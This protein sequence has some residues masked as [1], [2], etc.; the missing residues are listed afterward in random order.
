[1]RFITTVLALFSLHSAACAGMVDMQL[2]VADA[3]A[4]EAGWTRTVQTFTGSLADDDQTL[5]VL[6]TQ[7]GAKLAA[8]VACDEDCSD[9]DL[10][11]VD[12]RGQV[13]GHDDRVNDLVEIHFDGT[14]GPVALMVDMPSCSVD[15]CGYG[16]RVYARDSERPSAPRQGRDVFASVRSQ[17]DEVEQRTRAAGLGGSGRPDI[18]DIVDGDDSE[19]HTVRLTGGQKWTLVGVCDHDCTDLDL[20]LYD[21]DGDRVASDTRTDDLPM[22]QFTPRTT[23]T[24]RVKASMY[25]CSTSDCAYGI[26]LYAR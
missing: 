13:L 11:V 21:S 5:H 4:R 22:L 12:A 3:G 9:V 23:A 17:L 2:Q 6:N 18:L 19:Y 25:S 20:T 14:G 7:R 16:V 1:M 24:Y 15:P 10:K 26:G 8:F